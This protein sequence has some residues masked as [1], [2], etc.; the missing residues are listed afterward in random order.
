MNMATKEAIQSDRGLLDEKIFFAQQEF[1][2]DNRLHGEQKT[3]W[4]HSNGTRIRSDGL[5]N[6]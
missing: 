2:V 5:T 3:R 1:D 6:K 4:K